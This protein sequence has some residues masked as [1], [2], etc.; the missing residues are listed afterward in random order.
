MKA[1]E[2]GPG[3][4]GAESAGSQNNE[5]GEDAAQFR[6]VLLGIGKAAGGA[7]RHYACLSL[8]SLSATMS[9]A[10]RS[11]PNRRYRTKNGSSDA[12]GY[13]N[14][15]AVARK[16]AS[17]TEFPRSPAVCCSVA[18]GRS[19]NNARYATANRPNSQKPCAVAISV[20]VAFA[21]SASARARRARFNW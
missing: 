12:A 17:S 6:P 10:N 4:A 7:T 8:L 20:T 11:G 13:V 1:P 16:W 3:R 5:P 18:E 9:W 15:A 19:P 21:G 2:R 14:F